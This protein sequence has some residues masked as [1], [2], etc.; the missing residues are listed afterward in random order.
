MIP[1][2][3]LAN[4]LPKYPVLN[5]P[6]GLIVPLQN[7]PITVDKELLTIDLAQKPI[8]VNVKYMLTNPLSETTTVQ[9]LFPVGKNYERKVVLGGESVP[10]KLADNLTSILPEES[11]I[12]KYWVDPYT[13]EQYI[14]RDSGSRLAFDLFKFSVSL[15]PHESKLLSVE[16]KQAPSYDPTRFFHNPV[17]RFDYL[18]LPAKHWASYKD[19]EINLITSRDTQFA[20]NFNFVKALGNNYTFKS[21]NLPTGNLSIF[22]VAQRPIFNGQFT[23]FYLRYFLQIT[24]LFTVCL[25]VLVAIFLR[26]FHRNRMNRN[27]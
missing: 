3:T 6:G 21:D 12:P 19:L 16:Y 13:N 25:P 22:I 23:S 2:E 1:K 24:S 14:P 20:S 11:I 26:R 27:L 15:G 7:V 10:T 17:D 4:G 9:V 5:K 8:S 18:L